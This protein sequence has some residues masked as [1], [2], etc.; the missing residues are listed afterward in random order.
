MDGWALLASIGLS[1]GVSFIFAFIL[2]WF[3]LYEKE[4]FH[5]LGGVFLWG[6]V[7]AAGS[8]FLINTIAGISVYL[9]TGSEIATSLLSSTLVAPLIEE[10]LKGFAVLIVFFVFKHEFDSILDGILYAGIAALGFAAT[11]NA[12]YI[13]VHGYLEEGWQGLRS[14]AFIRLGLV[15]WQHPFYTAFFGIGLAIARL[16]RSRLLR[17]AAPVIGLI[18]AISA[19]ALHNLLAGTLYSAA[20]MVLTTLLD[21]FGWILMLVFIG[22]VMLAE[23]SSLREQLQPEIEAGLLT[24]AQFTAAT[25]LPRL[26]AARF[27]GIFSRPNRAKSRFNRAAADL[28]LKKNLLSRL[29]STEENTSAVD[30]ARLKLSELGKML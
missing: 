2:Y 29:G 21:W 23:R 14:L 22:I 7:V 17:I 12:Y 25:S 4:P 10:I 28:A 6:A 20:G 1:F 27:R 16:N 11:E 13:Y 5:L 24:P 15:G 3:D 26:I 18:A 9:L 19:H 30:S 8:A